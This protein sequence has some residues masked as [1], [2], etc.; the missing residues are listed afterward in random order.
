MKE[1]KTDRKK[2]LKKTEEDKMSK[3]ELIEEIQSR[4]AQADIHA[5]QSL[6]MSELE[7]L[8]QV[9]DL[10]FAGLLNVFQSGHPTD[11]VFFNVNEIYF[12]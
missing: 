1:R 2:E 12:N 8:S 4:E 9:S 3:Q 6:S 5:L 11:D 7:T 10:H